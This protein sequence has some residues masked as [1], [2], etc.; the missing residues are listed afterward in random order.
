MVS[1]VIRRETAGQAAAEIKIYSLTGEIIRKWEETL[2][3]DAGWNN[4]GAWD[5]A[6]EEGRAVG[7]G[8]YF[9]FIKIDDTKEI[10]RIVVIK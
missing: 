7:R 10:R 2:S 8:I 9:V 1:V 3:L 6:N 5:G 4:I